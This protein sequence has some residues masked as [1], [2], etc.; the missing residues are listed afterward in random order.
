MLESIS[1]PC[2]DDT[3]NSGDDEDR[4]AANLG[5]FSRVAELVDDSW[6]KE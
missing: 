2:S 6:N 5:L 1:T 3:D 4:D